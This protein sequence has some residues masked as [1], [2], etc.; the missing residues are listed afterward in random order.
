MVERYSE[1]EI[2][3]FKEAFL[4]FDRDGDGGLDGVFFLAEIRS[5][6]YF[7]SHIDLNSHSA[8][9]SRRYDR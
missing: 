4:L 2:A 8:V 6:T 3:E 5:R 7:L 9:S 1:E